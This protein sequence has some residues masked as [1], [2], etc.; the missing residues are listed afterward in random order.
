MHNCGVDWGTSAPLTSPWRDRDFYRYLMSEPRRKLPE[1]RNRSLLRLD[2]SINWTDSRFLEQKLLRLV[3]DASAAKGGE[4]PYWMH[5]CARRPALKMQ[6]RSADEIWKHVVDVTHVAWY[7]KQGR[8]A[9][10]ALGSLVWFH[11]RSKYPKKFLPQ[12]LE[13]SVLLLVQIVM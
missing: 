6:R 13:M 3:A 4:R 11:L 10:N 2:D 1:S 7:A 8:D 12:R 9:L 5:V